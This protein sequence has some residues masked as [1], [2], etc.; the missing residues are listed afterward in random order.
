MDTLEFIAKAAVNARLALKR[1]ELS[2]KSDAMKH[3]T[4]E[5]AWRFLA[6]AW[7]QPRTC[8]VLINGNVCYG[9]CESVL[10]LKNISL[11]TQRV[12]ASKIEMSKPFLANGYY[13]PGT[14]T[15]SRKRASYCLGQANLLKKKKGAKRVH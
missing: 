11:I 4:E 5:E 9:L 13:W 1:L 2:T 3:L 7:S 6:T 14:F 10:S 15:G 8:C 12:M